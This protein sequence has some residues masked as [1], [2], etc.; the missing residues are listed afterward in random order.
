MLTKAAHFVQLMYRLSS[1]SRITPLLIAVYLVTGAIIFR[2]FY[3]QVIAYGYYEHIAELEQYG[4]TTLPARRGEILVEDY[5]TGE[6]YT[7]ATN[8]TLSMIYADP[9]LISDSE[10][11]AETLAPLL[12][13]HD[14]EKELDDLSYSDAYDEV[15]KLTDPALM[16]EALSKLHHKTDEE[17][18]ADYQKNMSDS[19]A[20][21]T[22][23]TILIAGTL[24]ADTQQKVR[25]AHIQGTEV[26]KNGN[27][28]A[29]PAKI[30]DKTATAEE[31]AALFGTD[32]DSLETTLLG[33][34]RYVELK[35]KL[36]PEISAQI[37]AI[38]K[39]D[40][41]D[42]K[43]K[44]AD[45][46]T[47][48]PVFLGI[49]M[50]DEYF[51]FYPEQEMAAQ[52]LGFVSSAGDGN[53]GVE[54]TF[55]DILKGIDGIFTS[56]V[57]A[58]GNQIT[59]GKSVIEDAQDGANITLTVDRAIQSEVETL[60]KEGVENSRPDSGQVIVINPKTGAIL[61]L[62]QYPSFNPN[63]YGDIYNKIKIDIP[64][65]RKQDIVTA[66]T[67]DEPIYW[68]YVQKDPDVRYQVFPDAEDPNKWY[69]YENLLGPEVYK[70]KFLQDTY[71]PG[72]VFK[73]LVMAA[74]I[75]A[76]E[77]TPNTTFNDTGPM[78][79][80]L[81]HVT[82]EYDA[83]IHTF[84]N[85]YH[86]LE[87]MTQVLEHS[88][89]T[90][91]T[92]ISKKLGAALFYSYLKAFGFTE[93]TNMGLNDEALGK[94]AY[95]ESWIESEMATKAFGQGI[96]ITPMQLAQAYTA[97]FNNGT[98]MKP[99]LV[100][101]IQYADGHS[102]DFDPTAVRQVITSETAQKVTAMMTDVVE[103]YASI[104]IPDH[105]FAGKSGTAQTYSHGIALGGV[106]T[107]EATFI[108][109]GP[110]ADPEFLVIVKMDRPRSSQWAEG[111][112]GQVLKKVMAYLYDYYSVPPDKD[113][114]G[115]PDAVVAGTGTD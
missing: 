31:I 53:Y 26:T 28:Y 114:G 73:P 63:S 101:T 87:T 62:A 89:N 95:Y 27:Y 113:G 13:D 72:S 94:L 69:S 39:K 19:L 86:G 84:N 67:P 82:G 46:K 109:A 50:K 20:D 102:E 6:G 115:T 44:D 56:Q 45:G 4:Y 70:N 58:Y 71:E 35:H 79:L 111:T 100:K 30:N 74:A 83:I 85:Q 99:Y 21:R 61:A 41:E 18:F 32:A 76:G 38:L 43:I 68:Y 3:L 8:T 112:S 29:Y 36:S 9:T 93:R 81:N 104:S 33:K 64:D 60:L 34:N 98:M 5:H 40:R 48:D 22:R 16:A 106:G 54:G 17:L 92:F 108:G 51:R 103:S 24:D 52:V 97:I 105:Y 14:E 1:M 80:D 75:N 59:V 23:D 107:T 57:D 25:D 11:V 91:M 88:C 15:Q 66:G 110:I 10:K 49:G 77:V 12:Y 96:S 65:E 90:G 37:E 42:S 78:E 47:K 7:L 55:N 2:L